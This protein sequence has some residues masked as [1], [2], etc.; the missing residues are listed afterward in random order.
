M[1]FSKLLI[2]T[3]QS[4]L[5]FS[6][7]L[8]FSQTNLKTDTSILEAFKAYS[9]FPRE[10]CYTHL[11]KTTLFHGEDLGFTSYLF[12]KYTKKLSTTSTNVYCTLQDEKGI[13]M[14]SGLI[15]ATEGVASNVF[16]IDSLFPSGN[17]VFKAYTNW[18]K[19]FDEENYFVQDIKI[20]NPDD[21]DEKPKEA[22]DFGLDMQFLPEGGH[23]LNNVSNNVGVII[24]DRQ[25][26]GVKDVKGSIVD[27][28]GIELTNFT[29]NSFGFAKFL[30]TPMEGSE[31]KSIVQFGN[32]TLETK[33]IDADSKGINMMLTDLGNKVLLSL[34]TN[35]QTF[36]QIKD[37][38][39]TLSIHNGSQL[40]VLDI[41]FSESPEIPLLIKYESL[42]PGINIFTLFDNQNRPVLER[43]FFNYEGIP[44]TESS[45][46][47]V[48]KESDS[49]AVSIQI[50][51]IKPNEFNNFSI[52]VLPPNTQSYNNNQNIISN[53]FLTPYVKGYI[54]NSGYYFSDIDRK[55]KYHLDL[56]LLTQGWSSYDWKSIFDYPPAMKFDFETGIS[57]TATINR[58]PAKQFLIYPLINSETITVQVPETENS[59]DVK[60]LLPMEEER[61]AIAAIDKRNTANKPNLYLQFTPSSIPSIDN[62]TSL[63]PLKDRTVF[64]SQSNEPLLYTTDKNMVELDMVVVNAK[65]EEQKIE[66]IKK[67]HPGFVDI[68]TDEMRD[69]NVDFASYISAKGFGVYQSGTTLSV[70]NLRRTTLQGGGSSPLIYLDNM[71]LSDLSILVN[72]D[73]SRVDYVVIDKSGTG[74]G[75]RGAN[76]VIKIFTNPQLTFNNNA[77]TNISQ[78]F[79][80]P[81]TF[82]SEKKFYVPLYASYQNEFFEHFGVIDWLPKL[83]VDEKGYLNFKVASKTDDIRLYIEGVTAEGLFLSEIKTITI[84]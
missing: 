73:M 15:L 31:Y 72:Y 26:Y 8:G 14:K 23:L 70:K 77:D 32:N 17:Y 55:K 80:I 21:S 54:E 50:K 65:K 76:G 37:A 9:K 41:A 74:M 71:L 2:K 51:G 69:S 36:S 44:L 49:T 62:F 39:Y 20:I 67:R 13:V 35:S 11:N 61:L 83:K 48:R 29:T 47:I 24:K 52:S 18:M 82:K 16:E 10:I 66:K 42:Y 5:I 79:D 7:L 45:Q 6:Y 25:G 57:F 19:N 22:S 1:T 34:K 43:Q 63:L 33:L 27:A 56:L 60:G 84:R 68:L 53:A 30:I 38:A 59:F 3:I 28:D 81:L 64:E 58:S 75:M 78:T 12:D 46:A 4:V 40:K